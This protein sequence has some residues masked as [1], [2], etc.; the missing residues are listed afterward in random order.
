MKAGAQLRVAPSG[1]VIGYDM[2]AILAMANGSGTC[3][4]ATVEFMPI[5]EA[6]MVRKMRENQDVS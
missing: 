1:A 3:P 2:T 4:A 5:I 6:E